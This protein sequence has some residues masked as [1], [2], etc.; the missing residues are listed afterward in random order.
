[1]SSR[2]ASVFRGLAERLGCGEEDL[3]VLEADGLS[4][5]DE[6]FFRIPTAE[7]LEDYL[8]QRLFGSQGVR[9]SDG[10]F[11]IEAVDRP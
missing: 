8:G 3:A 2:V 7:R 6:L 11:Q 4:S 1:M 5:A 9:L 10:S